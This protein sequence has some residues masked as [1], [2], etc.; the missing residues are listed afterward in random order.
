LPVGSAINYQNKLNIKLIPGIFHAVYAIAGV[1]SLI[2]YT[3][4]GAT[5]GIWTPK[6]K[7]MY[8]EQMKIKAQI[9]TEHKKEIEYRFDRIFNENKATTFWDSLEIYNHYN[10]P[11]KFVEPTFKQKEEAVKQNELERSLK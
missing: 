3:F 8:K 9:E 4:L 10:L 7:E 6:Q 1:S 5:T 2:V 11:F